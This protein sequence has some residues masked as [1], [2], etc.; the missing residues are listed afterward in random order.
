MTQVLTLLLVLSAV[1]ESILSAARLP[2]ASSGTSLS[3]NETDSMSAEQDFKH[4]NAEFWPDDVQIG[5]KELRAKRFISDGFCTS[6]KPIKEVVCAGHCLPIKEQNLPWWSEFTKV[7][8]K[9]KLKEWRCVEAVTKLKKVQL[10]CENGETRTYKI[11]IVK[12]CRCKN[13]DRRPNRTDNLGQKEKRNRRHRRKVRKDREKRRR[14]RKDSKRHGRN[15]D[16]KRERRRQSKTNL[17]S[18]SR[19][20]STPELTVNDISAVE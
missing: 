5:C 4:R 16:R 12:S 13:F 14:D 18:N 17:E 6:I 3:S 2:N 20:D 11:K 15:N 10:M 8:A 7:W 19:R 1:I 9:P